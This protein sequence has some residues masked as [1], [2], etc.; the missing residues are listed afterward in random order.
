MDRHAMDVDTA[1]TLASV[2][3]Y[4][5]KQRY[6]RGLPDHAGPGSAAQL[7]ALG[8]ELAADQSRHS[9]P[10]GTYIERPVPVGDVPAGLLRSPGLVQGCPAGLVGDGCS[11][12]GPKLVGCLN[13]AQGQL[14][15]FAI[16]AHAGCPVPGHCGR[17]SQELADA[18]QLSFG[19]VGSPPGDH[20]RCYRGPFGGPGICQLRGGSLLDL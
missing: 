13:L 18:D 9:V 17:V 14:L 3:R 7:F 10:D 4:C 12:G 16:C 8:V 5:D 15:E 11:D 6:K 19:R 20:C 1:E 2:V